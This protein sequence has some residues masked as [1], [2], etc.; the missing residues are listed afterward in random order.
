MR[1]AEAYIRGSMM[2]ATLNKG[3]GKLSAL[4]LISHVTKMIKLATALLSVL[5]LATIMT[6]IFPIYILH[7]F[8]SFVPLS[9][10]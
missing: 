10:T 9:V 3:T 4:V 8:L 7:T 6:V 5:V 1:Y 2:I